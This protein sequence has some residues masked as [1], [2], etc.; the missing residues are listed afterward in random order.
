MTRERLV[1]EIEQLRTTN[2]GLEHE[3]LTWK[4]A[5]L[6]NDEKYFEAAKKVEALRREHG[7][8]R[9][10]EDGNYLIYYNPQYA[11]ELG[12]KIDELQGEVGRLKN[13]LMQAKTAIE[14]AQRQA[15][16]NYRDLQ[17][18][19]M[20]LWRLSGEGARVERAA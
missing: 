13:E 2:A 7:G 19:R 16:Q 5:A 15:G 17:A 1:E 3:L 18:L 6:E 14:T 9:K 11:K 10:A 20:E 4:K 12:Q 8:Y